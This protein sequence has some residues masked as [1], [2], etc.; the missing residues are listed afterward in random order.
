MHAPYRQPKEGAM[1]VIKHASIA[2][3]LSSLFLL[4]IAENLMV[5]P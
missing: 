1:T 2:F 4:M 3:V 5:S